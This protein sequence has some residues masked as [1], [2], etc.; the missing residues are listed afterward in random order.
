MNATLLLPGVEKRLQDRYQLLVQEHAGQAHSTA[1]GP[2]ILP[3]TADAKAHA[4][5]AWRFFHNP[6]LGLPPM[7]QPLV[8]LARQQTDRA[9]SAYGLVV[10]D[11]SG[12][13]YSGHCGK[14][15]KVALLHGAGT[16]YELYA[17]LL[18]G[19]R[20][21]QPLAPLRLRLRCRDGI[22][23][24]ACRRRQ[25]PPVHLDGLRPVLRQLR[26]LKLPRPLVHVIDAEGDSVYH[27]RQWQRDGH[28]FLVRTDD[29]RVVRH[30]RVERK[31]PALVRLL[32]RR[33]AF[34]DTRAVT[35]RGRQA[36]Q[37][38]AETAVT[39]ERP[40][41]RHR[42]VDGRRKRLVRVGAPLPLRL[43]VSEVRAADGKVLAR[44]QLLTNVPAE[45]DAGTVALW[46]YWRWQVESY[47]K[48]LKAAGQQLEHWQQED[49]GAIARRLLVASMACALV[50]RLARSEAPAAPAARRLLMQLSGRQVAWGKEFT[51]EA[52]LAGLWV[53][54]A[55][56]AVLEDQLPEQLQQTA[57]FILAGP[58]TG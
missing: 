12:L 45:V 28:L 25:P 40:S 33:G 17:A 34:R 1:A 8:E 30:G 23:D 9:C 41:W 22:Y 42:T 14:R 27:L 31:L 26:A 7:M 54:L 36:R 5:A 19:D 56:V 43:V 46:Y 49:A 55:V 53:L 16:G 15:D 24:S 50:W 44:W 57:A 39:L 47:F 58:D 52:L 2:R 21:G 6:R 37:Y 20:A 35:Y 13:N 51:E 48:L 29:Q 4:Q 38:V 10:H 3:S 11:W 18:L 32:R